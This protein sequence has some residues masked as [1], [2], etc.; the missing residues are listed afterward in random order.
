LLDLLG[1]QVAAFYNHREHKLY[2]FEDSSLEKSQDRMILA[3]ELVHA[4]QD[5]HYDLQSLPI[6]LKTNDDKAL[7][8]LSII[9]GDATMV[10]TEYMAGNISMKAVLESASSVF[11]TQMDQLKK[12]PRFLRDRLV[13]PYLRGREFCATVMASGG[14]EAMN[15]CYSRLPVSTAQIM[16][17]EKWSGATPESPLAIEFPELRLREEAP[18][19]DNVVGEL[20]V[21]GLFAE[22][23]DDDTAREIALDWR[24]D[25]FLS[26]A[27]GDSLVWKSVWATSEAVAQFVDAE[28]TTLAKRYNTTLKAR[29]DGALAAD[30]A[31]FLRLIK[32]KNNSALLI[33]AASA[34]VAA[35]LEKQFAAF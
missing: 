19:V 22:W 5:Q 7:A 23:L 21:R 1:E 32:G 2:M 30:E 6:G 10:M 14:L 16:H 3:H 27:T 9:E 18:T 24:G 31:R 13:F 20:G 26:Y 34:D 15:D 4:L 12:A 29:E 33:D 28:N 11:T 25:R 35:A 17:P 8:A